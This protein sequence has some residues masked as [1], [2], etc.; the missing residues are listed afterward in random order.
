MFDVLII[1]SGSAG[2]T[3]AIYSAR[4]GHKVGLLTGNQT[5]GQLTITSYVENYPGFPD[6]ILGSQLMDHMKK[7]AENFGIDIEYDT[8]EKVDFSKR[9]FVCIGESRKTYESRCVIIATGANAKWLGLESEEK[10]KNKGVS[11]CATCD[12]FFFRNKP[13]A[14]IG[15]GNVAVEEAIY[16]T[17][18]A[19]HIYLIHRRDTLRAEN[20]LQKRLFENPKAS[21]LWNSKVAEILGDDKKVTGIRLNTAEGEKEI[22]VDGIFIAI[23]HAPATK[24]FE[25][26]LKLDE[27][28]Y[29]VTD[30][31]KTSVEGV[32]A[33]GDV[34]DPFY[35][36]AV[37][38][39]GEGCKAAI[40]ADKFLS[41]AN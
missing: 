4:A 32:F 12:G 25:N 8:V 18:F 16:L 21:V 19:S 2:Y 28:G 38:A 23:G 22:S 5:G 26:Q 34:C 27:S 17:N 11:A 20:I 31:T 29:I 40:D 14:V 13:V 30:G 1:G 37:V 41:M 39:A 35:R 7:Q 6:K 9:P 36:Q 33:A 3:A 24:I 15:G 10:Y